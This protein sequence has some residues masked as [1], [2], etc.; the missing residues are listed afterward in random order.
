MEEAL[1]ARTNLDA[2]VARPV[3]EVVP[4]KLLGLCARHCHAFGGGTPK[5]MLDHAVK[6]RV[7]L[8]LVLDLYGVA[9]TLS[10]WAV[11]RKCFARGHVAALHIQ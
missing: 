8:V 10:P 4:L 3:S 11:L 7:G 9:R 5:A 1:D 6:V 2:I